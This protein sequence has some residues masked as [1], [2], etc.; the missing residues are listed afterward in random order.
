MTTANVLDMFHGDNN[1]RIPDFAELRSAGVIACV[2][3]ATQGVNFVDPRFADRARAAAD[4]EMPFYAYH[5]NDGSDPV[6]QAKRFIAAIDRVPAV[7]GGAL[8]FEDN[9]TNMTLAGAVAFLTFCQSEDGYAMPIYSGNR[10][11]ELLS[12]DVAALAQY[13]DFFKPRLL[14]LAEY[15]PHER[16]PAPWDDASKVLWQFSEDGQIGGIAGHVDTSYWPGDADSLEAA[17]RAPLPTA[18]A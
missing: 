11:R 17:W 2:H 1:E 13:G 12:Q 10:I 4:V 14:W 3:K 9:T 16:L 15:G 8:D 18:I 6:E 7:I 5:F